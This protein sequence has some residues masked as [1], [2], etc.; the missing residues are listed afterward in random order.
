MD[1]GQQLVWLPSCKRLPS[2]LRHLPD[3]RSRSRSRCQEGQ[4]HTGQSHLHTI[5]PSRNRSSFLRHQQAVSGTGRARERKAG[6]RRGGGQALISRFTSAF[7][8]LPDVY[9]DKTIPTNQGLPG[10]LAGLIKS[11]TCQS[12]LRFRSTAYA[13][14]PPSQDI[15]ADLLQDFFTRDD[16]ALRCEG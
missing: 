6:G 13:S 8:D 1:S 3:A 7:L 9:A 10:Y 11:P 14:M 2:R 4:T 5:P 12:G 15:T 16:F